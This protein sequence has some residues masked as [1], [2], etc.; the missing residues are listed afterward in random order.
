M[1][2][3]QSRRSRLNQNSETKFH[4]ARTFPVALRQ[5]VEEELDCLERTKIIELVRHSQWAAPVVSVIKSDGS[6]QLCGDYRTTVNQAAK[7]HPYPLLKIEDLFAS[8]AGGRVFSKL[9]LS[10]AYLQVMLDEES[11]NLVTVNTHKGLFRFNG[12]L[13][14]VASA[15]AIFKWIMEGILKEYQVY[16]SIWMTSSSLDI[17]KNSILRTWSHLM[18]WVLS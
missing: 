2:W 18:G 7:L 16:V 12:L 11:R 8:L 10:H 15:P 14:G 6:I 1:S 4:K 17:L 9:D 13:L 5:K 3:G